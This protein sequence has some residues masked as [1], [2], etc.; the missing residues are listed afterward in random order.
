MSLN[1]ATIN[2]KFIEQARD[3][4]IRATSVTPT[5]EKDVE[6]IHSSFLELTNS[7]VAWSFNLSVLNIQSHTDD[8]VI[9]QTTFYGCDCKGY[10]YH[11]QCCHKT[12][13]TM[14]LNY[15]RIKDATLEEAALNLRFA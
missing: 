4:M 14:L 3:M 8:K 5:F 12:T 10:E 6:K 11:K 1:Y 7:T 2:L 9:H 13:Y 15:E